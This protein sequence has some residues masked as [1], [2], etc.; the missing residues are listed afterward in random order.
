MAALGSNFRPKFPN[1][2][3][4]VLL[5]MGLFSSFLMGRPA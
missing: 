1:E 3:N 4:L 2:I 5:C